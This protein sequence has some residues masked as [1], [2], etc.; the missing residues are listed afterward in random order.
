VFRPTTR[1]A[2]LT[3]KR[4]FELSPGPKSPSV[5][6]AQTRSKDDTTVDADGCHPWHLDSCLN[7]TYIQ[8]TNAYPITDVLAPTQTLEG[9]P[10][11]SDAT[12]YQ[13]HAAGTELTQEPSAGLGN[14][15]VGVFLGIL[16]Q[17]LCS[18]IPSLE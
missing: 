16:L 15:C 14:V 6:R 12:T 8:A 9:A 1:R 18:Y 2:L 11:G 13:Q 5:S 7:I 4:V 10:T 3:A 17:S